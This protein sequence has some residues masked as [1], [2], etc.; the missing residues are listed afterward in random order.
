MKGWEES[1]EEEEESGLESKDSGKRS[2]SL[3]G[4]R[5]APEPPLNLPRADTVC[6]HVS[7]PTGSMRLNIPNPCR[8]AP[9]PPTVPVSAVSSDSMPQENPITPLM[10][11]IDNISLT[12]LPDSRMVSERS[13]FIFPALHENAAFVPQFAATNCI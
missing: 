8:A 7:A 1:K 2:K 5:K 13:Y 6:G 3:I 9:L 12:S 10:K 11:R 4:H